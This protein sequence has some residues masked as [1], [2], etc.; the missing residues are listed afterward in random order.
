MS[1]I[2]IGN[3]SETV[4]FNDFTID[5]DLLDLASIYDAALVKF[6][7]GQQPDLSDGTTLSQAMFDLGSTSQVIDGL[8]EGETYYYKVVADTVAYNSSLSMDNASNQAGFMNDLIDNSTEFDKVLNNENAMDTVTNNENAM[9]TVTDSETATNKLVADVMPR[10]KML[11]S[12]YILDTMWSKEM[13]SEKFWKAG[14]PTIPFTD[15]QINVGTE[16]FQD[17]LGLSF[18]YNT[19]DAVTTSVIYQLDLTN[20]SQLKFKAESYE[21][22]AARTLIRVKIDSTTE[23]EKTFH[24]GAGA[25]GTTLADYTIDTAAYEGICDIEFVGGRY[26]STNGVPNGYTRY[27]QLQLIEQ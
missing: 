24:G 3:V 20:I 27:Y 26:A 17:G 9:D 11:L 19:S 6:I 12:P 5:V 10:T 25:G 21:D 8:A 15:N 4:A 16:P 22:E 7:Y 13:A 1:A 23:I 2:Q 18:D 14:T